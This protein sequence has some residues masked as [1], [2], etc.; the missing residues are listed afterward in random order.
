MA[1]ASIS[2]PTPGAIGVAPVGKASARDSFH[3]E[4]CQTA[5][6]FTVLVIPAHQPSPALPELVAAVLDDPSHCIHA[7][8]VVDDGSSPD[9]AETFRRLAALPGVTVLHHAVNLGQGAAL[10]TGFNYALVQYPE[11]TSVVAADADGQHAPADIV[12]VA[13]ALT[14]NP[15]HVVL[16]ARQFGPDVPLRS[17]VG[18]VVTRY[19]FR[20][21]TG[22][23]ISDTQTGLRGWPRAACLRNLR[24]DMNGF[25][26][27]LECLLRAEAPMLQIPIETIYLDGN[28]S[29]HFS[30]V[31]D[32]MRIYFLFLR[33]C[34]SSLFAAAVD[35]AVFYPVL[36]LTG[37]VALSQLAGRAVSGLA[38]FPV[39]KNLVF[40]SGSSV[41]LALAKYVTLL[42]VSGWI[43]YLLIQFFHA[44]FGF[45]VAAAKVLAE[46]LL[47]L[48][49][50]VIQRDLIFARKRAAQGE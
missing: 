14:E 47:F 21:F 13:R 41:T 6:P 18:N 45:P 24:L 37:N 25:D 10:R 32:S 36:F 27:Q 4:Q 48:G 15:G 9:C 19:I 23:R 43:S 40:R 29:S 5:N 33:Y 1:H 50:F 35:S 7:A 20:L 39:V 11:A 34:G 26:F 2:K 12:R 3:R 30:P 31:R 49:N 22:R 38:N 44:Q 46:V 17:R 16:G 42:A 8:V 28:R